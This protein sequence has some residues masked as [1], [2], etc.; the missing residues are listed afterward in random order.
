VSSWISFSGVW[1]TGWDIEEWKG[2]QE[3][4]DQGSKMSKSHKADTSLGTVSFGVEVSFNGGDMNEDE[5]VWTVLLS[6]LPPPV[7]LALLDTNI[8]AELPVSFKL[9]LELAF[10]M[11]SLLLHNLTWKASHFARSTLT[12]VSPSPFP[13]PEYHGRLYCYCNIDTDIIL[14][15]PL[16]ATTSIIKSL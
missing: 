12:T 8:P 10:S 1:E 7:Y 13:I 3:L 16:L 4:D 14:Q 11:L 2:E 9:A 5:S 15:S 6:H